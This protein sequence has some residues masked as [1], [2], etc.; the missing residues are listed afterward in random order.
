MRR[1][2]TGRQDRPRPP[3]RGAVERRLDQL[4]LPPS[5]QRRVEILRRQ[6]T[7]AERVV[8]FLRDGGPDP[9][10]GLAAGALLLATAGGAFAYD[11]A[12]E[13][14]VESVELAPVRPLTQE[15]RTGL[16]T[17]PGRYPVESDSVSRDAQGV[18]RFSW[19]DSA[20]AGQAAAVS[21]LKQ[22]PGDADELEM[23]ARGDPT[24]YLRED[25]PIKVIA[26]EAQPSASTST[27]SSTV[28]SSS[29]FGGGPVFVHVGNW[30][31]YTG[32]YT[33]TPAY[34]APTSSSPDGGS[35]TG[36]TESASP[37]SPSART[38][39]VPSRVDAVSGMARGTGAGSAVSAKSGVTVG[40]TS[41][42]APR[43]GGFSSGAK[44]SGGSAS[45][46]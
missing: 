19:L 11:V 39:S 6:Q 38:I 16:P 24:L 7:L 45:S 25:T 1:P 28:R 21:L 44:G 8:S 23:P 34:R 26:Q 27:S 35:Y 33:R 30:Y 14:P 17:A 4:R 42:S 31:P 10:A 22:A 20:G 15:V 2:P 43:S 12:N 46:S 37:S 18:F 5:A 29:G 3:R 9:R 32:S 40:R 13:P 41:V 36:S